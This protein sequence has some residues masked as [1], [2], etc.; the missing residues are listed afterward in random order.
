MQEAGVVA[1]L[2]LSA[3]VDLVDVAF[4]IE[5]DEGG[6][7]E[8]LE[9][10]AATQARLE[11]EATRARYTLPA[12]YLPLPPCTNLI[13]PPGSEG[14]AEPSIIKFDSAVADRRGGSYMALLQALWGLSGKGGLRGRGGCLLN[15]LR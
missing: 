9:E 1:P 15:T 5:R 7:E 13:L 2:P 4:V 11:A 8:A 12:L 3:P 10:Y 6:L 14:W